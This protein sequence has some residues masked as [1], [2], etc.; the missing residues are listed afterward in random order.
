MLLGPPAQ[1]VGVADRA[2]LFG[3]LEFSSE[4]AKLGIQPIVG[5]QLALRR[6]DTSN[7]HSAG[8]GGQAGRLPEPD[9]LVVLCQSAEGYDNLIRLVS[10]AFIC[11]KTG[12]G[13]MEQAVDQ[14]AVVVDG[15]NSANLDSPPS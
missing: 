8:Q 10:K 12:S 13:P 6:E 4:C 9:A 5:C 11:A 2:N 15:D 3:A 1:A 7:G 14:Q